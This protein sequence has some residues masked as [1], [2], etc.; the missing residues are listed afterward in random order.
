MPHCTTRT[1]WSLKHR[2]NFIYI[3]NKAFTVYFEIIE[4]TLLVEALRNDGSHGSARGN[5]FCESCHKV[6]IFPINEKWCTKIINQEIS[7]QTSRTPNDDEQYHSQML[8][9]SFHSDRKRYN[10]NDDHPTVS[11][12]EPAMFLEK[13]RDGSFSKSLR[14]SN[15]PSS[16]IRQNRNTV[17][18]LTE[19][20][21]PSPTGHTFLNDA[22]PMI[23]PTERS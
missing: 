21:L 8:V 16:S 17:T 23:G 20:P 1:E 7:Q 22:Y 4:S 9:R 15:G 2:L 18:T 12:L 19:S 10:E 11:S 13:H 3:V 6:N 5:S 14:F